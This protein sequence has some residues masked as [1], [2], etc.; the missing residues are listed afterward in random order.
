MNRRR[1][2]AAE[3]S[4]ARFRHMQSILEFGR[5]S[6]PIAG[7]Y[8]V[9]AGI[10]N[11]IRNVLSIFLPGWERVE[12]LLMHWRQ[13]DFDDYHSRAMHAG[14]YY[15]LDNGPTESVRS[16][17]C[18]TAYL[19]NS[20]GELASS[21]VKSDAPPNSLV[22]TAGIPTWPIARRNFFDLGPQHAANRPTPERGGES[23]TRFDRAEASIKLQ[24]NR[25]RR[26]VAHRAI[27]KR[28]LTV[29]TG[30]SVS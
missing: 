6:N 27:A 11:P 18:E 2:A 22:P 8:V 17:D 20:A 26:V 16:V 3:F 29:V 25:R 13:R 19:S 30:G 24:R 9:G 12:L 5:V 28:S 1:E 4:R 15:Q 10:S 14:I 7:L 21:S 23:G